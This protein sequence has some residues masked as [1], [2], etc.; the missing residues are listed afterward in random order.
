MELLIYRQARCIILI[1]T[2][3]SEA[4]LFSSGEDPSHM[5]VPFI[6]GGP[7]QKWKSSLPVCLNCMQAPFICRGHEDLFTHRG[8]SG[9]GLLTTD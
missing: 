8:G 3:A 5:R 4:I 6:F 7:V 2:L 9:W 1:L